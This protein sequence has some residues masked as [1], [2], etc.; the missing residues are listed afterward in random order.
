MPDE[1]PLPASGHGRG[2]TPA[3][4]TV[5]QV[6]QALA[7]DPRTNELGVQIA[8]VGE[9]LHLSGAAASAEHRDAILAVAREVAPGCELV[10]DVTV[11]DLT[12]GASGTGEAL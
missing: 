9:R 5:E 6:R 8:F 4:Y 2:A 1:P 11:N 7:Q 10:D 12:E 3:P